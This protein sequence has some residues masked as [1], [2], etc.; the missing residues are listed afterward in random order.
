[1]NFTDLIKKGIEHKESGQTNL[2]L[3][4]YKQ[5]LDVA[6]TNQEKAK[7]WEYILH[8]H[9]D[10]VLATLIKIAETFDCSVSDL[11]SSETGEQFEWIFGTNRFTQGNNAPNIKGYVKP[12]DESLFR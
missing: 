12:N 2:A 11:K 1:M 7:V 8:I 9:T 10:K 6:E 5:A 4:L 3:D